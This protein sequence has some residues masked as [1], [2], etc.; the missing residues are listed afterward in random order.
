MI[1]AGRLLVEGY[2]RSRRGNAGLAAA[3]RQFDA[4]LAE[5]SAANWRLPADI[6]ARYSTA[7]I[8]A[9]NRVV[10]NISGNNYRLVVKVNYPFGVVEIRFFGTHAEYDRIKAETV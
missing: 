1:I 3:K 6:K 4:W 5:A 2:F 7:S 10:F 8:V 9:G